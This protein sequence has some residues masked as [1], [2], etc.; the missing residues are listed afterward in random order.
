[1]EIMEIGQAAPCPAVHDSTTVMSQKPVVEEIDTYAQA[2]GDSVRLPLLVLDTALRI[3]S[4]NRAFYQTFQLSAEETENRLLFELGQ[5]QWDLPGLRKFLEDTISTGSSLNEFELEQIFPAVGRRILLLNARKVQTGQRDERLVLT[6]EDVTQR[7]RTEAHLKFIE[8]Y[9]Q[10]IVDAVHEPLLV[11]DGSLRIQS[12]NSA[13][14][15]TFQLSREEVE[16]CL[17]FELGNGQWDIPVLRTL[18]GNEETLSK[19]SVFK[20]LEV[21]HEFPVIG[22]RVVLLNSRKLKIGSHEGLLVLTMEDVTERRRFEEEAAK[23]KEAAET[24][25]KTKSLFLA[26]MSHE[27]RTP[28][29]AILGYSEMLQEEA[30][31]RKLAGE[32][33]DELEKI[34]QAVKHLLTL[35]NDILDFSKI[36]AGKMELYLE[37]FDLTEM[38]EEVA[39]TMRPMVEKSTNALRIQRAADLGTIHADQV[40]VRQALLNLLSNAVKFT[41]Q[42]N[43]TL[44][45]DRETLDGS[46]WIVFR[47][48]DTGIG[49]TP[50]QI[51]KLFRNFT[52]AEASTA[53]N[54][55]GTGLG[56]VLTRRYCQ[57]MGGDVTVRS[58]P[59]HGSVFTIRLPA[60]VSE[61]KPEA[62]TESAE[63]VISSIRDLLEGYA[64]LRVATLPEREGKR[65]AAR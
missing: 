13:F 48:T 14:Y 28:L 21:E 59:G 1:M 29:N 20:D 39:S 52:Q 8:A 37:T 47:V 16:H 26:N 55:G 3:R 41:H 50:E 43:I 57:M 60:V 10:N 49:L 6:M 58:V 19:N 2:I 56:L 31:E 40:K 35:I 23:A 18:L 34:N 64:A 61:S 38:M 5:S 62:V 32:F 51:V 42:G 25:N 65:A 30:V 12:A 22:R 53:R 27:L 63:A 17:I 15:Q 44:A 33:G 4:A 36:E 7:R 9:A 11:L 45:A 46:E 24:A 54:F